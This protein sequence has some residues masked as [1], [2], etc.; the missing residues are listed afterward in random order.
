VDIEFDPSKSKTN[1]AARGLSF[2]LVAE[3]D[4]TTALVAHDMRKAY[5]EDRFIALGLIR[6]RLHVVAFTMRGEVLR[7]ISL[8][9]ANAREVHRYEEAYQP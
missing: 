8:R 5:G 4:F 3:F 9:K 2:S 7:V 6:A 1:E